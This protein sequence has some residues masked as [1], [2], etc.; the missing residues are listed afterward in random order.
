M[1]AQTITQRTSGFT[2]MKAPFGLPLLATILLLCGAQQQAFATTYTYGSSGSTLTPWSTST[3]T[4]GVPSSSQDNVL[5]FSPATGLRINSSNDLG[6]L[7]QLNRLNITNNSSSTNPQTYAIAG[8]SLNFVKDSSNTLPMLVLGR[9]VINGGS[10]TLSTP[11]TVTDALTIANNANA[12]TLATTIQGA[13][14]NTGGMTFNGSGAAAITLGTGIISGVGGITYSGSYTVTASGANTYTGGTTVSAGRL[15]IGNAKALGAS[16]GAASVSSGAVLDLNG[17]TM[18]NTNALTVNGTGI[19]SGGALTNSSATAGT[20]AGLVTLGSASS[21]VAS[22]GNIV[23]SNVGT[24]TGSGFDLALD[25]TATGSSIVSIIDTGAGAL[26]KQGG[27]TWTLSGANTYTGTTTV[28]GGTLA[29][30]SSGSFANSPVIVIGDTGSSGAV[31]D[32]TSKTGGFTFGS[33][34][35]VKGIGTI[36]IGTGT[37]ITINGNLAPGNSP[38][39]LNVTGDLVLA[40][41]ATVPA[42]GAI[43]TM[44]LGGNG[45]VAGTDYDKV[46]VSG[47][48]TFGGTLAIVSYNSYDLA[49]A[50]T[51]HLFGFGSKTGNF[52]FVSVASTTLTNNTTSWSATNL[53]GSGFD[54]T[55]TLATGDLVVM[56]TAAIPEP[57]TYAM[58]AGVLAL[59]MG[60][61]RRT[62]GRHV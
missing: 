26:T 34:Q 6:A 25:G 55:F 53:A 4:N 41:A 49:Q 1:I 38:G 42:T 15:K 14:T 35:T 32:L 36:N 20:Y 47:Q 29:L 33:S 37:A 22:S 10:M 45:G 5:T 11:F 48:L 51:Y 58:L 18:T 24:I 17:I 28:S 31:L 8:N 54:Y 21:I 57:S 12:T 59:G 19:S 40:N 13:I 62:R 52:D 44:E 2:T 7:F 60:V 39:L 61:W 23:L 43:T 16:S 3:W 27:G 9:S 30:G 56:A 46:I 50:G